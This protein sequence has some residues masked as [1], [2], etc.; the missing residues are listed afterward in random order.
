M[1]LDHIAI[2]VSSIADSVEWYTNSLDAEIIY[3]DKTW[4]M[5]NVKG[6]QL[7]LT[8]PEQHPAH[9]AFRVNNLEDI[10]CTDIRVHRDKTKYA[11]V[12][13]PDGNIIEYIYYPCG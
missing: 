9:I 11:Y 4:A 2:Q 8:L 1:K 12:E 5:L 6:T 13:D 10:P 7:A 3:E